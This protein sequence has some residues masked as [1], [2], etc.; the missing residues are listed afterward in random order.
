MR[1]GPKDDISTKWIDPTKPIS[2]PIKSAIKK[3]HRL[4]HETP[5]PIE[6]RTIETE[7]SLNPQK[8]VAS[9]KYQRINKGMSND[10]LDESHDSAYLPQYGR[11]QKT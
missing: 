9:L 6:Q 1:Y 10:Y 8:T 3:R 7:K 4:R 11:E 5:D 2:R